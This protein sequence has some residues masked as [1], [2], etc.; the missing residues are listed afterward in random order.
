MPRTGEVLGCQAPS[1][2]YLSANVASKPLCAAVRTSRMVLRTK[3]DCCYPPKRPG[4][5]LHTTLSMPSQVQ[6]L[7]AEVYSRFNQGFRELLDHGQEAV[8]ARLMQEVTPAFNAASQQVR[9]DITQL[10]C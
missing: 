2:I 1:P 8:F 5:A 4:I 3:T 6:S 10:W 9:H 7:R